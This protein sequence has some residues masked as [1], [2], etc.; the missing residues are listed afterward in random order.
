MATNQN[1]YVPIRKLPLQS[2][3]AHTAGQKMCSANP[4][5]IRWKL[6]V[7]I[8]WNTN[9]E[10]IL[11]LT[12]FPFQR[13][14]NDFFASLMRRLPHAMIPTDRTESRVSD[15]LAIDESLNG[16]T[17]PKSSTSLYWYKAD[18]P[19]DFMRQI[20]S[21]P[22]ETI[23]FP[24]FSQVPLEVEHHGSLL[25]TPDLV[26][27]YGGFRSTLIDRLF[28]NYDQAS[29]FMAELIAPDFL[30]QT[31]PDNFGNHPAVSIVLKD[32]TATLN[33]ECLAIN[34]TVRSPLSIPNRRHQSKSHESSIPVRKK[35]VK[36][37][38]SQI[39]LCPHVSLRAI[40]HQAFRKGTPVGCHC[41]YCQSHL[42]LIAQAPI[43]DV[44]KFGVDTSS[45][46]GKEWKE[47]VRHIVKTEHRIEYT[48]KWS[49]FR[50]E[51]HGSEVV[52]D[53]FLVF[54]SSLLFP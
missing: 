53:F 30:L 12:P 27:F 44:C 1:T 28:H 3:N 5:H 25:S 4:T 2:L 45:N 36:K 49:I 34:S 40:G 47:T 41:K 54:T 26:P 14:T 19:K 32:V 8:P 9:S 7:W 11:F 52:S 16:V 10:Y 50:W 33:E 6:W 43:C 48:V 51:K 31:I 39:Q 46:Q 13:L 29:P 24:E 17:D 37:W 22:T 42:L 20:Y 23:H 18:D 35:L 15:L 21:M 38:C